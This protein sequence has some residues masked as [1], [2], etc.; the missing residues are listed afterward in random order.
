MYMEHNTKPIIKQLAIAAFIL[1]SVT[2]LS[3]GIR[4]VRF[5]AYRANTIENPVGTG[6]GDTTPPARFLDS[7]NQPKSQQTLEANTEA[8]HYPEDSHIVGAEPDPYRA[9]PSDLDEDAP[10]DSLAEAKSFNGDYAKSESSKGLQRISLSDYEN[11]YITGEGQL[12]YVSK[13]AD[14]STTKMQVKV[15]DTGDMIIVDGGNYSRS[16]DSQ[17]LQRITV[18]E[19]DDLYLTGENELW[20]VSEQ[21]DGSTAKMQLQTENIGG[22][23]TIVGSGEMNVYPANDE[24]R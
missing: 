17:G 4:Y 18:G 19:N 23:M 6:T 9:N 21:P 12:W 11:L 20:Y 16:E 13:E 14:G 8:D 24:A 5:S 7:E 2:I 10:W 15:D 22:E 3:F 1:I